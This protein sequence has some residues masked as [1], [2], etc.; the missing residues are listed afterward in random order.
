MEGALFL[1]SSVGTGAVRVASALSLIGRN[2]SG[3]ERRGW[4]R[5]EGGESEGDKMEREG[6]RVSH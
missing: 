4:G 6:D 3:T 5:K 1:C 2:F